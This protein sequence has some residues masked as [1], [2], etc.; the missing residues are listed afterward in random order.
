VRGLRIKTTE[1]KK[2]GPKCASTRGFP[3]LVLEIMTLTLPQNTS[4][5]RPGRSSDF[6][7]LPMAFPIRFA[8]DQWHTENDK[9]FFFDRKMR[10]YSGGP[11]P[12]FNKVPY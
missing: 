3:F 10:G 9:V 6:P 5:S 11:V 2:P 1:N 7:A 8:M 4:F 12:E